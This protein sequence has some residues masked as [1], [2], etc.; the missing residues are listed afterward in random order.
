L[1]LTALGAAAGAAGGGLSAGILNAMFV[2]DLKEVLEPGRAALFLVVRSSG[3]PTRAID[4]LRPLSPRVLR[5]TL[6]DTAERRLRE[7]FAEQVQMK[8]DQS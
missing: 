5:T 8:P 7:A 6:N 3:D 2:R 4:A 1:L